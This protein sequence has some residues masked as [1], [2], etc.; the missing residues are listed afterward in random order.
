MN[1]TVTA[2]EPTLRVMTWNV[3][4]FENWAERQAAIE[5]VIRSE[6]PDIL[7]LQEVATAEGQSESLA[8]KLGFHEFH[9]TD[10]DPAS[11]Y[12]GNA[13]L[14]R[15]PLVD[16][17]DT[18]LPGADGRPAHRSLLSARVDT[19][20][21]RWPI[22]CTHLDHRFDDSELRCRQVDAVVD[23]VA[24]LRGDPDRDR[25][26][27]LGGDFNAV[28]DSDEIRRLTGRA[29]PHRRG[30]VFNDM[31]EMAGVG[32]GWTWSADNP[33]LAEANWP[34]RRLDYLFVSWPRPKPGGRP[35]SIRLTGVQPVDGIQPSDHY[36]VVADVRV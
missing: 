22:A 2:T 32:P 35:R 10:T 14:S 1:T 8:E 19:P 30:L 31:W 36:A 13:I 27:I 21:G 6:D 25:P 9:T 23:V 34:N 3:L 11:A 28:P 29:A 15:W 5:A 24:D 17:V 18:R 20:W 7:L 12:M 26:V 4:R 16:S 33:M